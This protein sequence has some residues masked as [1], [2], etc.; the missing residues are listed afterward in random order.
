MSI[1]YDKKGKQ[2]TTKKL[3]DKVNYSVKEKYGFIPTSVISPVVTEEVK[4]FLKDIYVESDE[5]L[6]D[7]FEEV[8]AELITDAIGRMEQK[9]GRAPKSIENF[10]I[11]DELR[12]YIDDNSITKR[13]V[14]ND[15][16]AKARGG[17]FASK[18]NYSTFNPALADYLLRQHFTEGDTIFDPFSGRATRALMANKNKINYHGWDVSPLTIRINENK[19]AELEEEVHPFYNTDS[20]IQYFL[21]DGTELSSAQNEFYDGGLTCPPYFNI[22][23]YESAD[24]QLTD[25]KSYEKFLEHYAKGFKRFAEVIKPTTSMDDFHPFI[26]VTGNFRV[27]KQL[28]DFTGDT[29]RLAKEAGFELYDEIQHVNNSPFVYLRSR[30]NEARKMVSKVHETVSIFIKKGNGI[31]SI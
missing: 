3:L 14:P 6:V 31:K 27:N 2:A 20:E 28:I 4:Q 24:G 21:G 25:Y 5:S 10:S 11:T 9:F 13:V 30:Q 19:I 22:E 12:N 23:K 7:E 8:L 18:Y 16:I 29:R 17:G 26:V 15:G 1:N